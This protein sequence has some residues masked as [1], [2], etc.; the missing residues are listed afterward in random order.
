MIWFFVFII[1]L[2]N[3]VVRFVFLI[4]I[5]EWIFLNRCR[6]VCWFIAFNA[7]VLK[8]KVYLIFILFFAVLS[9]F[10]VF[11]LLVINN[12]RGYIRKIFG[13][14]V[15]AYILRRKNTIKCNACICN[16]FL[17]IDF[18]HIVDFTKIFVRL[19]EMRNKLL[20]FLFIIW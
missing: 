17:G 18:V 15:Y 3:F 16:I 13:L 10:I 6:F 1:R 12:T 14:N 11:V 20:V 2:V 19:F 4:G 5:I 7:F 9:E 8:I